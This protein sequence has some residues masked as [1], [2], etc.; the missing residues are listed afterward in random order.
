MSLQQEVLDTIGPEGIEKDRLREKVGNIGQSELNMAVNAP[1]RAGRL[2]LT[3]GRYEI[4]ESKR[5][6]GDMRT[7]PKL[8]PSPIDLADL[9]PAL[10]AQLSPEAR[11]TADSLPPTAE[12][13]AAANLLP[14]CRTCDRCGETKELNADNFSRN[15][16][17]FML[18]CKRCY[19]LAISAGNKGKMIPISSSQTNGSAGVAQL[20]AHEASD[21]EVAS[22]ENVPV[23]GSGGVEG[24]ACD[25]SPSLTGPRTS[26]NQVSPAASSA[27]PGTTL[28]S[29]GSQPPAGEP[30]RSREL[31]PDEGVYE[32]AKHVRQSL[33]DQIDAS[34]ADIESYRSKLAECDRFLEMYE[35]FAAEGST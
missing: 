6:L 4:V 19:G 28:T 24:H 11:A 16:H 31:R 14:D 12:E 29:E 9:P 20:V 18:I 33:C 2:R 34:E 27:T 1:M 32:R 5:P 35:Q 25:G 30:L 15:R 13:E 21:S 26:E 17:G 22:A 7:G 3:F 23:N 10:V 8:D